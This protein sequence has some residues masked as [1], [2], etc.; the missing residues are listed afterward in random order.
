M[1]AIVI[2]SMC[3]LTALLCAILLLAAF[4][5]SRSALLLWSGLCFSGLFLNNALLVVEELIV[6]IAPE[7][8]IVRSAIALMSLSLLLVGMI[9]RGE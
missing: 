6:P 7:L 8:P 4:R 9:W 2:Y 5:S 3:A 1:T